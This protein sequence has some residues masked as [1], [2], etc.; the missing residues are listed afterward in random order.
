M[1]PAQF[2]AALEGAKGYSQHVIVVVADIQ[3]VQ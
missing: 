2:S 3:R 1:T